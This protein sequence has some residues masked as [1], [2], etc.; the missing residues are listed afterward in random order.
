MVDDF[1]SASTLRCAECCS[2][3]QA[4]KL[5]V[6]VIDLTLIQTGHSFELPQAS[7]DAVGLNEVPGPW[8]VRAFELRFP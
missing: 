2:T 3:D 5:T 4:R 8:S 1:D 6:A 7:Q